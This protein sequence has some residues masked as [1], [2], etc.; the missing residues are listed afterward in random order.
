MVKVFGEPVVPAV[1]EVT[2]MIPVRKLP[3]EFAPTETLMVPA[4]VPELPPVICTQEADSAVTV[5]V[6]V[7]VPTPVLDTA[8]EVAP[9]PKTMSN[10]SGFT[11]SSGLVT[12][13]RYLNDI[14]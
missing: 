3:W 11:V 8:K 14:V 7:M 10:V 4:L 1:E 5:A 2:V 12:G 13:V 9:P 6:Q